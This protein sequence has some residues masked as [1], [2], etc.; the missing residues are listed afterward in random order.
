MQNIHKYL[1]GL[2]IPLL[3]FCLSS[4]PAPLNASEM[5]RVL[6]KKQHTIDVEVV[7][8]VAEQ[9][10]GLGQ[11]ESLPANRGMLFV[12][13]SVGEKIFWMKGMKFSI[14]IIWL[15]NGK[16]VHIEK[17]VPPPSVMTPN[18]HLKRYG[19]GAYADSV[20]EVTAGFSDA[21][22]LKNGDRVSRMK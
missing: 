2:L 15:K 17:N 6:I 13:N 16:I 1:P 5:Q 14:D 11:R 8:S 12:Y 18:A 3:F 19:H 7:V 20:L 9:R 4:Q 10:L 21:R 22:K